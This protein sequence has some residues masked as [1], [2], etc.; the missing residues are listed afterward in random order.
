[1]LETL[2]LPLS[3]FS[4]SVFV[5]LPTPCLSPFPET[6][7]SLSEDRS[8]GYWSHH[9]APTV[10]S[11]LPYLGCYFLR[12]LGDS[13]KWGAGGCLWA[14]AA[15]QGSAQKEG[16]IWKRRIHP[17]TCQGLALFELNWK[18][19]LSPGKYHFHLLCA[20]PYFHGE[21]AGTH[22]TGID[23]SRWKM[24]AL[25][26]RTTAPGPSQ[27]LLPP[28]SRSSIADVD[29][30]HPSRL[31]ASRAWERRPALRQPPPLGSRTL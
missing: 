7:V 14:R 20:S 23:G 24:L 8:C 1:M 21:V 6:L 2:K 5:F 13:G 9:W 28:C 4:V 10:S 27:G 30:L 11:A 17:E 31:S 18:N 29:S 12:V 22:A 3:A 16:K 19:V 25:C 15:Y 26:S